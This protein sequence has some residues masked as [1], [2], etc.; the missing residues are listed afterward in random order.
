MSE[1]P[2]IFKRAAGLVPAIAA[3]LA[4]S[5]GIL[6]CTGDCKREQE[7]DEGKIA[8]Y[9]SKGWPECCG[10]AM[11]WVTQQQLDEEQADGNE[12]G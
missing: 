11:T 9:L 4:A 12:D 8:G 3:D 1:I 5:G 10:C 2:G 7:L 6:R